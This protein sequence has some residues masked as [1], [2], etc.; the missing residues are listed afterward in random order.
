MGYLMNKFNACGLTENTKNVSCKEKPCENEPS[1]ET[2]YKRISYG[3]AMPDGRMLVFMTGF[4]LGM[5]FF[6]LNRR[7]QGDSDFNS[8]I[9]SPDNFSQIKNFLVYKGGLLEYVLGIRLSQFIFI[10]LCATSTVGSILAYG[11]LGWCGFELALLVFASVYQYGIMGLLF[12]AFMFFPH[13]IFYAVVFLLVFNKSW[14]IDKNSSHNNGTIKPD[15]WHKRLVEVRNILIIL[16][17]FFFGILTETYINPEILK[18]I[19]LFF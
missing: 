4:C 15:S 16:V 3:N 2:V 17:I 13:G 7:M 8:G 18:K 1:I 11:I 12:S 5:V 10:V 6:Y 19:A 9:F 14:K